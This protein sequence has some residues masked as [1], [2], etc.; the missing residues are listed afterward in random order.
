MPP[1][2]PFKNRYLDPNHA[3]NNTGPVGFI[4][5]G[6]ILKPRYDRSLPQGIQDSR[7]GGHRHSN[8]M[9]QMYDQQIDVFARQCEVQ[10]EQ[11][12]ESGEYTE[13]QLAQHDE[14]LQRQLQMTRL[15]QAQCAGQH[16]RKRHSKTSGTKI[17]KVGTS[18]PS[19]SEIQVRRSLHMLTRRGKQ[20][21][22][23]LM[24]VNM[25]SEE[26]LAVSV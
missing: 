17:G 26:E 3:V 12:R 14:M 18:L 8:R 24:I 16:H 25:P 5:G 22:Y 23:Y 20:N 7:R 11:M 4:T 13:T 1:T 2:T 9:A 10:M 15:C 6:T 21:L 19:R